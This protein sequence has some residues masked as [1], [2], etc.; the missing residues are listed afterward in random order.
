MRL[1]IAK[2][3]YTVLSGDADIAAKVQDP[4]TGDMNIYPVATKV[5]RRFP[6]ILFERD[7]VTPRYDKDGCA[8]TEFDATVFVVSETYTE[9][10][11]IAEMVIAALDRKPAEYDDFDVLDCVQTGAVE[12]FQDRA[13]VQQIQFMFITNPN[14]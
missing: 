2:H 9:G 4:R 1:N 3:I 8:V 11:S 10:A 6:L 5:E 13:F 14:K 7:T 12:G